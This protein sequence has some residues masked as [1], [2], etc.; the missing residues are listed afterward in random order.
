MIFN[1]NFVYNSSYIVCLNGIYRNNKALTNIMKLNYIIL[2]TDKIIKFK[3]FAYDIL[4]L[5]KHIRQQ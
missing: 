4:L 5:N 3:I 1:D 2:T